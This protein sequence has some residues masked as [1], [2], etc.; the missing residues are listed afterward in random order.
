[1]AAYTRNEL[2]KMADALRSL[3]AA[4]KDKLNKQGVVKYLVAEIMGLQQRG[5]TVERIAE[6]LQAQGMS[7]APRTLQAYRGRMKKRRR[8]GEK[9]VQGSQRRPWTIRRSQ[10]PVN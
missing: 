7:I 2:D 3:P 9:T 4:T 5:Y 10:G 6:I 8:R 1:M